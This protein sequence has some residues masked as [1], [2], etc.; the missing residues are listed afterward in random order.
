MAKSRGP[1]KLARGA[2]SG[3]GAAK[4]SK[5]S[6]APAPAPVVKV[7]GAVPAVC[8]ECF[9]DF[10]VSTTPKKDKITCPACGHV[11]LYDDEMFAEV[12][13]RRQAH[14]KS[15]L[16]ALLV[17]SLGLV[18]LIAWAIANSYLF[19][20]EKGAQPNVNMLTLGLGAVLL[21]AGFVLVFKYEKSRVEVYF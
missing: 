16:L 12:A 11:G 8:S 7:T 13:T 2:K 20:G 19:A 14:R 15:F 9:G 10:D 3:A 1:S 4:G 6:A 17:N 21:I 18:L 5:K